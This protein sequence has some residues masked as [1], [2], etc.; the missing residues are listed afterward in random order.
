M[1]ERAAFHRSPHRF[2]W[3]ALA[4]LLMILVRPLLED[5]EGLELLTDV[6]FAG[7]FISGIYAVGEGKRGFRFAVALAGGSFAARIVAHFTVSPTPGAIADGLAALFFF[8]A[9]WNIL[10]YIRAARRVNL[11]VIFASVCA[12]LL[13]GLIFAD[14]CFFLES[15]HPGS[16]RLPDA[17]GG[18][19]QF[20]YYSFVTLTTLGYGDIVA[21]GK[22]ARSLAILE[23]VLGQ[24]YL[25]VLIGW[26][27]GAYS[28]EVREERR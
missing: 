13:L 4:V 24:L 12:Y 9:L 26:L 22:G 3:L 1:Q 16:F 6:F 7:I 23:A 21:A 20:I 17:G 18:Q 14:A 10:A 25:A 28:A 8:H 19:Y 27:V 11:D 5:L 15:T 2:G